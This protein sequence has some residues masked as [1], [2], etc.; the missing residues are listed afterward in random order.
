MAKPKFLGGGKK[1]SKSSEGRLLSPLLKQDVFI[2]GIGPLNLTT[3]VWTG[4][5]VLG[6]IVIF[7]SITKI[8][9]PK[10]TPRSGTGL[11]DAFSD[12]AP[13]IEDISLPG[14]PP[15]S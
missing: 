1:S 14:P 6:S 7:G 3:L 8:P 5:T 11:R 9:W 4:A 12:L 2:L 13:P 10:H 15:N